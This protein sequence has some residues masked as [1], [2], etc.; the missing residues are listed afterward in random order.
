MHTAKSYPLILT[1][2]PITRTPRLA[3]NFL[4]LSTIY[5]SPELEY[6]SFI[7]MRERDFTEYP[8]STI[9]LISRLCVKNSGF[10]K[11]PLHS[12]Q[13]ML[14]LVKSFIRPVKALNRIFSGPI[15]SD[16]SFILLSSEL[17]THQF[18]CFY[19][20]HSHTIYRKRLI[21]TQ[22]TLTTRTLPSFFNLAYTET[23]SLYHLLAILYSPNLHV[24]HR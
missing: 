10:R 22:T 5:M 6:V 7:H 11:K 3:S 24:L 17:V 20:S 15:S 19:F 2:I 21:T 12:M 18:L 16:S 8:L 13:A 9:D 14:H 1:M 4:L 23:L